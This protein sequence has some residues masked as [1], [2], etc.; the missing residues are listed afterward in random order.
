MSGRRG[1][2]THDDMWDSGT[3][4]LITRIAVVAALAGLLLG[5]DTGVISGALDYIGDAFNLS[6]IGKS[7]VVSSVLLGAVAGSLVAMAIIDRIGRRRSLIASGAVFIVGS[8][9]SAVAPGVGALDVARLLLGVAI[10]ISAVAAPMYI[11]EIAPA[12][13]RGQL[14]SFFQLMI[15]IGILAAYV[16]DEAFSSNGQWRW[17]LVTG[18]APAIVLLIGMRG[19]PESPRWFMLK[20]R[21]ADARKVLEK[22]NPAELESEMAEMRSSSAR[23]SLTSRRPISNTTSVPG[24]P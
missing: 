5:F 2:K 15:T 6:D 24:K 16:N 8:V 14:V 22:V 1:T 10:G 18:V 13:R 23:K 20:G 21:D 9:A 19:L 7:A 11:T 4:G 3:Q 17:M 12:A